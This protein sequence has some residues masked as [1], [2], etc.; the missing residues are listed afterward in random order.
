MS[1][2]MATS[3]DPRLPSVLWGIKVDPVAVRRQTVTLMRPWFV[4]PQLFQKP[5]GRCDCYR[6]RDLM[7]EQVLVPSDY[8]VGL[9]CECK[10][11]HPVVIGIWHA[12]PVVSLGTMV[13]PHECQVQRDLEGPASA[14]DALPCDAPTP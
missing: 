7:V 11:E 14:D 4:V 13:A 2:R 6:Q 3:L 9:G 5:V 10:V 1:G 8:E 12:R